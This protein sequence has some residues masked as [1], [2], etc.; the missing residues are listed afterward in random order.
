MSV[1]ISQ[2]L[3]PPPPPTAFSPWCPYVCS[4][5]KE[6]GFLFTSY[7]LIKGEIEHLSKL[8]FSFIPE[9]LKASH[10]PRLP[11]PEQKFRLYQS[12][13]NNFISH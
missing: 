6:S 7:N 12:W 3:P 8:P 2:F 9:L 13:V 5:H 4:L 1:P 11:F 10:V